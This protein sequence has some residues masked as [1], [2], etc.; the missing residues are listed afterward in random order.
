MQ[1]KFLKTTLTTVK[2]DD[3]YEYTI[4]AEID[5]ANELICLNK[6]HFNDKNDIDE[7]SMFIISYKD[8]KQLMHIIDDNL[9]T[10]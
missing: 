4:T 7:R 10:K 8:I 9:L 3:V 2:V 5:G 1:N 6:Y